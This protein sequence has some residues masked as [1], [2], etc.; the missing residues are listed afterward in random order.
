MIKGGFQTDVNAFDIIKCVCETCGK[1]QTVKIYPSR[2]ALFHIPCKKCYNTR[3][4]EII[5]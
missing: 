5:N 1:K 2:Q 3:L 4:E